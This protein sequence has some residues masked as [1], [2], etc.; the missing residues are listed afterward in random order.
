MG[1]ASITSRTEG[2]MR[3]SG[4]LTECR[5]KESCFTRQ[6]N[7]RTKGNGHRIRSMASGSCSMRIQS[8]LSPS[9][10]KISLVLA[11]TGPATKVL[12]H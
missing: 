2:I 11:T 8:T 9:T 10:T 12:L 7:W 6:G 4:T 1:L 5:A 3:V